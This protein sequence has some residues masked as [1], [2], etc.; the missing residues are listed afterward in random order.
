VI[1]QLTERKYQLERELERIDKTIKFLTEH[2]EVE[3]ML[4]AYMSLMNRSPMV[5]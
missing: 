1:E 3:M 4:A 2:P 5:Y